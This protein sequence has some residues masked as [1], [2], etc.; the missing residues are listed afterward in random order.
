MGFVPSLLQP[1]TPGNPPLTMDSMSGNL[2]GIF[3]VNIL[4]TIVHLIVGIWGIIAYRSLSAARGYSIL[5]GII[6]GVL[7][8]MGLIPG[9]QT[10][11]GLIPLHGADVWLHLVTSVLGLYFGLSADRET[12]ARA[13]V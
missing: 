6:F 10:I 12:T 8:L 1:M 9:L 3:P 11:F 2:L 7:F 5:V 13:T 4:H